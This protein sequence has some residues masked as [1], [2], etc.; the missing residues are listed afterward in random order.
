MHL[1]KNFY[2]CAIEKSSRHSG[3]LRLGRVNFKTTGSARCKAANLHA[4]MAK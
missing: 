3:L 2:F 4:G 1:T